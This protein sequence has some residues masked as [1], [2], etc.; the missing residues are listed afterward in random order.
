MT[1]LDF[2]EKTGHNFLV[3]DPPV[4]QQSG[5]YIP[6]YNVPFHFKQVTSANIVSHHQ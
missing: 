5:I 2:C 4:S 3:K 1:N 6:Q